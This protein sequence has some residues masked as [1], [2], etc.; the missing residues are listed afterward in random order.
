MEIESY[1][2][3]PASDSKIGQDSFRSPQLTPSSSPVLNPVKPHFRASS[4]IWGSSDGGDS[5]KESSPG[6]GGYP[7]SFTPTLAELNTG[8]DSQQCGG[9][10]PLQISSSFVGQPSP[11]DSSGSS[12]DKYAPPG[13]ISPLDSLISHIP[14]SEASRTVHGQVTPP[15]DFTKSPQLGSHHMPTSLVLPMRLISP[16]GS[17][18]LSPRSTSPRH[19]GLSISEDAKPIRD[20]GGGGGGGRGGCGTK[21]R[22]SSSGQSSRKPRKS[23][24]AN[25]D[26]EV[27]E[28]KRRRFLERN[29]VAASKC[30]QKKKAW[31]QDLESEAREAQ[32]MSKQL[33]ACVSVLKE[34][35]LQLKNEL[36]KHN[37]CECM[38]IRQYLSN[39]AVRLADGALGRS[40]T[41]PSIASISSEELHYDS[42]ECKIHPGFQAGDFDLDF[43]D[44]AEMA[45]G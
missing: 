7:H 13:D 34:E 17:P 28:A 45:M 39:E 41:R 6:P 25:E 35:I 43:V 14:T 10:A 27:Q 22:R 5:M 40:S 33:K 42:N 4:A 19:R 15:D 11:P 16:E 24:S 29:R 32:N 31:M 9:I 2:D 8:A 37:T 1:F 21:R 23:V 30:R 20:G 44:N 26:S 3:F 36:L 18:Q 38:P 12:P